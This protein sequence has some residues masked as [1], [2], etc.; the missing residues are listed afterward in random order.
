[1]WSEQRDDMTDAIE[2]AEQSP[3]PD[4]DQLLVDVYTARAEPVGS[5]S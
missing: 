2:F 4:P 5:G 1:M 3:L